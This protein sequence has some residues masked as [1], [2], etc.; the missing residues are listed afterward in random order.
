MCAENVGGEFLTASGVPGVGAAQR[1]AWVCELEM[2]PLNAPLVI[3]AL[4]KDPGHER[5]CS[6][7]EVLL[8]I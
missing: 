5:R 2:V 1:C 3:I 8:D 7:F 6:Q 4:I